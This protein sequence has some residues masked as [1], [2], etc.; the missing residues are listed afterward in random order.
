MNVAKNGAAVK[1]SLR[2]L[3][4][5]TVV[6]YVAV[7]GISAYTW[8]VSTSTQSALCTFKG[9]LESRIDD[10]IAFL[11]EHPNGIAGISPAQIQQGITN[12]QK[13]VDSLN[14]LKCN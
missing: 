7:V 5:A 14:D 9:D 13:T 11:A 6:L 10:S 1:R 4:V 8:I 3:M 2:V 12:Q